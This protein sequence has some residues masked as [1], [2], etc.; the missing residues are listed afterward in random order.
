MQ[1]AGASINLIVCVLVKLKMFLT[2]FLSFPSSLCFYVSEGTEN[3]HV[4]RKKKEQ[5]KKRPKQEPEVFAFEKGMK[6]LP[7]DH[8]FLKIQFHP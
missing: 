6:N 1:N 2:L 7:K 5:R 8:C 3:K 4:L